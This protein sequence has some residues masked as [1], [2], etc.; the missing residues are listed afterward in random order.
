MK[1]E[2][3]LEL[4][5]RTPRD[6]RLSAGKIRRGTRTDP[7]CPLTAVARQLKPSQNTPTSQPAA[8]LALSPDLV[9][10]ILAASDNLDRA[11]PLLRASLLEAC[12]LLTRRAGVAQKLAGTE[13]SSR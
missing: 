10:E 2:Q 11:D 3:F 4:L 8:G 6:W 9:N 12:G 1:R 7:D 5:A 13:P